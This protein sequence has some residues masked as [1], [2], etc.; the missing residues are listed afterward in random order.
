M[1]T[2][3]S[4]LDVRVAVVEH[5]ADDQRRSSAAVPVPYLDLQVAADRQLRRKRDRG[6]QLEGGQTGGVGL[7]GIAVHL[8]AAAPADGDEV[9]VSAAEP[10][11]H[12]AAQIVLA[13]EL[14]AVAG[15]R[16]CGIR[17]G[18]DLPHR[19]TD[20]SAARSAA[21][22]CCRCCARRTRRPTACRCRWRG[23][24]CRGGRSSHHRPSPPSAASRDVPGRRSVASGRR[25]SGSRHPP[26]PAAGREPLPSRHR[27]HAVT[28][29]A[30]SR[31]RRPA[32]RPARRPNP[33]AGSRAARR[34]APDRSARARRGAA[35][36]PG[37]G[38]RSAGR[39]PTRPAQGWWRR[40]GGRTLF[41]GGFRNSRLRYALAR[42]LR[43]LGQG[44]PEH[45]FHDPLDLRLPRAPR[46]NSLTMGRID[47]CMVRRSSAR[48]KAKPCS[49]RR[50]SKRNPSG[51]SSGGVST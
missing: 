13:D 27:P 32:R 1:S 50:P 45:S 12:V 22:D 24:W 23:G 33:A 37:Y 36:R 35:W 18:P 26:R 43:R 14:H 47:G 28:L 3:C 31:R 7:A 38:D 49:R 51:N 5:A 29:P 42:L 16:T 2:I 30:A 40:R 20:A 39:S 17:A 44:A 6:R 11:E 41:P 48:S 8:D 19:R 10:V 25:C 9:G 34:T 21:A 4:Q 15:C 46:V